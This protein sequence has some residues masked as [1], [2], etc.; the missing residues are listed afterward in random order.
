MRQTA[1]TMKQHYEKIITICCFLFI[2]TNIGLPSTSFGVY[3]PYI[4][5][6]VG[7][8][9][10]MTVLAVRTLAS[11][12]AIMFVD[13]YYHLLDCRLGIFLATMLTTVG[14]TIYSFAN[15]LP[16]F[17]IASG[18]TGLGYGLGGMVGMTML[19]RR[20]YADHIGGAV[21]FASVGS[22][23]ASIVIPVIAVRII[24]NVSLHASFRFEAALALTIGIVV[25]VLLRN[26]P[27]DIGLE[28]RNNDSVKNKPAS[29]NTG[30]QNAPSTNTIGAHITNREYRLLIIAACFIGIMCVGGPA[31]VTVYYTNSGIAPL[32]AATLLS[33]Q[34]V[35][36]T[37]SKYATGKLFDAVGT[38]R[39]SA[40]MFA[41]VIMGLASLCL[42]GLGVTRIAPVATVLYGTGLS[43]G[44]VG[45]SVWSIELANPKNM[46]RSIKNYQVAYSLGGF[47]ANTFPGPLK[48]LTGS[49]M[50]SYAVMLVTALFAGIVI[51][52]MYYKYRAYQKNQ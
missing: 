23:V 15:S 6:I 30:N 27:S 40:I 31:Y 49:Y 45:I 36:L 2:F 25:L 5:Q 17:L 44:T 9:A 47:L 3:Q 28:R 14:F 7:D 38:G 46:T 16:V 19:T 13:R 50:S 12:A 33:L 39:G 34:G 8:T 10:G 48:E 41:F 29:S 11:M 43:L 18:L 51:V 35:F 52:G 42:V 20:W 37:V 24:E 32:F 22:G 21:G 1:A 4:V 26:R